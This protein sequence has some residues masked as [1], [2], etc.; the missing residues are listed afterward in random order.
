VEKVSIGTRRGA[1]PGRIHARPEVFE[2]RAAQEDECAASRRERFRVDVDA[3]D[4]HDL[5][6]V[7]AADVVDQRDS[8]L[9]ARDY[10]VRSPAREMVERRR[11]DQRGDVQV[12][13]VGDQAKPR[14]V[15]QEDPIVRETDRAAPRQV[16]KR[17][18]H[19]L[20]RAELDERPPVA[21]R[22]EA[23]RGDRERWLPGTG[24]R[25]RGVRAAEV[26]EQHRTVVAVHRRRGALVDADELRG[27][28]VPD[29]DRGDR[30]RAADIVDE[31]NALVS[32]AG[33]AVRP[34]VREERARR[35][36]A[37]HPGVAEP[38]TVADR[39]HAERKRQ[40]RDRRVGGVEVLDQE[41]GAP[42]GDSAT[43]HL[44][45][46]DEDRVR[47]QREGRGHGEERFIGPAQLLRAEFQ[48]PGRRRLRRRGDGGRG[49]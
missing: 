40:R 33:A 17:G 30:V 22:E 5:D 14:G 3:G 4:W 16:R 46:R 36:E 20:A 32:G 13:H 2:I 44:D 39:H 37:D 38:E 15:G 19:R 23:R 47:R 11:R 24:D 31:E 41:Q 7:A 1:S 25:R 18:E 12:R 21:D 10:A 43:Q 45:H 48:R 6:A 29:R 49:E 8:T 42:V 27:R 35:G 28:H 26:G 9:R 34:R